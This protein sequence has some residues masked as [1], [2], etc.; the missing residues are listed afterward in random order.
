[1]KWLIVLLIIVSALSYQNCSDVR[2]K[3]VEVVSLAAVKPSSSLCAPQGFSF[4]APMRIIF[5]LDMSMSNIGILHAD[6]VDNRTT[7][8]VDEKDGPTDLAGHRF[9]QV[10]KFI[11]NCGGGSNITYS[12]MGFA[13]GTL[14][15]NNNSCLS[16]FETEKEALVTINAMKSLQQHDLGISSQENTNPYYLGGQT[17][18]HDA[19]GCLKQKVIENSMLDTEK[20]IY[21]VFFI[22]DGQTTDPLDKQ[23]YGAT[24]KDIQLSLVDSA[25]A[26]N[27]YPIFY[28][29]PGAKN[30]SQKAT[31]MA[32]L[33]NMAKEVNADVK[34]SILSDLGTSESQFCQFVKPQA[35]VS[36]S[37][38]NLYA[39]NLTALAER[40]SISSDTDMDG[41]SDAKESE[42]GFDPLSQRSGRYLDALCFRAKKSQTECDSIS[43]NLTC[44]KD[45]SAGLGLS[46][47][48]LMFGASLFG[49]PLTGIDS[50][51]DFIPDYLEIV[52]SLHPGR[53]DAQ[54]NPM[55]DGVS[56]F[57]K[58][59]R[60]LDINSSQ[61]L[62]P[63]EDEK[64]IKIDYQENTSGCGSDL[65]ARRLYDY[66]IDRLPLVETKNYVDDLS[67]G[68]SLSHKENENVILVFSY[69]QADGGVAAPNKIYGQKILIN[70]RAESPADWQVAPA[71]YLGEL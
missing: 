26:F 54:D 30:E 27:F 71:V 25:T 2:I 55:V 43:A 41:L 4:G 13:D 7:Y 63:I 29:S 37:L 50:D 52:R 1:M 47:C 17:F 44:N 8:W 5:I 42:M 69:W 58:I 48:D 23:N 56:N 14:F 51:S 38:K 60:G 36:Y 49:A 12:I 21:N 31:A 10:K 46:G 64:T 61:T 16:R 15:A 6:R 70:H 9:D 39:V 65:Q 22:T 20:P 32:M 40:D 66:F 35:Y 62:F 34:T 57:E 33:D 53:S 19:L 24:L 45:L 68:L 11:E 59:I 67:S 28:T 3:P 18:Y